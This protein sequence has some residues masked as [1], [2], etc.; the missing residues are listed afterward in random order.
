MR[1]II[2]INQDSGYLIVDIINSQVKAG[3]TCTLIT[4]RLI[5]RNIRL[6]PS[7]KIEHIIT[8]RRSSNFKRI[9]T[10]FLGSI[11]IFFLIAIRYRKTELFIVSNPPFATLLP[12]IVNNPFSLLIFDIYP[13]ALISAN[14]IG[15]SSIFTKWWKNANK[16]V[17][18][19]AQNIYTL[20]EKMGEV[21]QQYT[22]GKKPTIVPVWT[23]SVFLKPVV[24][25]ANPFIKKHLLQGKFIAMYSGN[26][27]Y[28][29][30]LEVIAEIAALVQN[31]DIIFLIIGEGD[32]KEA[33]LSK[34]KERRLTNCKMLPWQPASEIPYSLAAADLAIV[35]SGGGA[36]NLSIPS[37]TYNMMSVGAPLLCLAS[38]GSEL[39]KLTEKHQNGRC[40]SHEKLAD[41]A[42]YIEKVASNKE[43]RK[44]LGENSLKAS[45]E[46]TVENAKLF[47]A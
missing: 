43:Y 25:E 45:K 3:Y 27:G 28:T 1:N 14:I 31:P 36:S 4:G 24:K 16:K 12:F 13:D 26:L 35:S 6:D 23:D 46:Y 17:Y 19:K 10:W 30:N 29:H 5:E 20:T 34:I 21:I 44:M 33:L 8:Y 47:L 11:Q 15:E 7:V 42:F 38:E 9:F 37:K 40:F 39:E 18:S 32:S 41:I 22:K 2:I